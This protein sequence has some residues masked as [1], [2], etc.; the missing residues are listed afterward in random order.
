[1][2]LIFILILLLF[3][4]TFIYSIRIIR[5]LSRKLKIHWI[6]I[7]LCIII[8]LFAFF[9]LN[10]LS[11]AFIFY[12]YFVIFC[13]LFDLIYFVLKRYIKSSKV[14]KLYK[15][16]AFPIILTMIILVYGFLNIRNIVGTKYDVYTDKNINRPL[17]ILFI[18]DTHYGDVFKKKALG[19]IKREL[20]SLNAD[21]VILGGDIVDEAT[22]KDDMK[23][24]FKVLGSIKNKDGIYFVYGNHDRQR[25]SKISF[26]N[27]N[28]LDETIKENKINILK[29]DYIEIGNNI[30][31]AGREDYGLKRDS[32][33]NIIGNISSDKY[34]IMVDHQPINYEENM[35]GGVDLII[36]GHT[37]AGQI[38]PVG[39]FIKL[40]KTS[41]LSYGYKKYEQMDA[42][43]SSGLVGWGFPIRTSGKSEYVVINIK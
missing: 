34:V 15:S 18:S 43:V 8:L 24:I 20:D 36:S 9:R 13:L 30:V 31:I 33:K 39:L 37:H 25:Y 35:K 12:V 16:F 17:K 2:Y 19:K 10:I 3:F 21:V 7:L 11:V 32:V 23:Y 1:M 41:D 4:I 40:F 42:I 22:S 29:D 26:Y 6:K 28:E 14:K 38:F 27:E 5:I